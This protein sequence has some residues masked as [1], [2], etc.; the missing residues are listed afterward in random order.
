MQKERFTIATNTNCRLQRCPE[1][2]G[3]DGGESPTSL[4]T[5]FHRPESP[6]CLQDHHPQAEQ[7]SS[8]CIGKP[9]Q[10]SDG[11]VALSWSFLR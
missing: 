9:I 4:V 3:L 6:E 10:C 11:G 8:Q 2:W 1:D 7:P 5:F